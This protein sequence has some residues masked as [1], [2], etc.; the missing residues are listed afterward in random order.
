M[1]SKRAVGGLDFMKNFM[2]ALSV[3]VVLAFALVLMNSSL[4]S[5]ITT[6]NSV[7]EVGFANAT[8]YKL[9]NISSLTGTYAYGFATPAIVSLTNGTS[10][11]AIPSANATIRNGIVYNGSTA[12]WNNPL[13]IT[14]SYT[15]VTNQDAGRIV[16]NYTAG[17]SSL[18]SSIATWI[19]LAGL[20]IIIGIIVVV[21]FL[22]SKF[23]GQEMQ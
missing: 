8:G 3:I 13:N 7:L 17:I 6:S 1:R 15:Y 14:Y 12:Q 21:I 22:V 2:I 5:S 11:T 9:G 10:G 18:T 4:K 20:V 23:G 16:Q 19:T